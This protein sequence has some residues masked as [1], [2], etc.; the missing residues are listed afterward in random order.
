M[1]ITLLLVALPLI[2]IGQKTYYIENTETLEKIVFESN[3]TYFI[4]SGIIYEPSKNL[5]FSNVENIT[6]RS[7]GGGEKPVIRFSNEMNEDVILIRASHHIL[8]ENLALY[9]NFK[10]N[11]V[12]IAGHYISDEPPTTNITIKDCEVAYGFNGVRSLPYRTLCDSIFIA[13]CDIHHID[14]DGVFIVDCNYVSIENCHIWHVNLDWNRGGPNSGDCIHLVD[15]C[16]FWSIRNNVLDRRF[17]SN[18]FCFIYGNGSY[19]PVSGE[20]IG[21]TFY[22]PKDT[23]GGVGTCIYIS[24]SDHVKIEGNKFLGKGYDWGGKPG[25]IAFVESTEVDFEQNYIYHLTNALFTDKA[26]Q[27]NVSGNLMENCF[28]MFFNYA[29]NLIASGNTF[30]NFKGWA[31]VSGEY[32]EASLIDKDT[33]YMKGAP[34]SA[35][36]VLIR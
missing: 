23:V 5:R 20:L 26:K 18:K 30:Y 7:Y 15:H 12:H 21:N 16:N 8:I 28:G 29:N 4:K 19:L 24:P 9:G 36:S 17:T 25:A 33:R 22:P 1:K 35:D 27:V 13:G 10:N 3:N 32:V 34:T 2:L 14:D 31:Y 11:I 6:F